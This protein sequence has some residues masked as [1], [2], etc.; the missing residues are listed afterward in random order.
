MPKLLFRVL[1]RDVINRR[2]LCDL[3]DLHKG[4]RCFIICNGPSLRVEDLER[5][6]AHGDISIG[7]NLIGRIYSKTS[8]RAD[9]LV[10]YDGICFEEGN[11]EI[12]D[13]TDCKGK[14]YG[15]QHFFKTRKAKGVTYYLNID[16]DRALLDAPQFS[17]DLTEK[18]FSIGTSA[19]QA[20]Q[21]ARWLG[22]TEIYIIGCD[23]SYAV[24]VHRDGSISKNSKSHFYE[25]NDKVNKQTIQIWEMEAAFDALDRLSREMGFRVYNATRG[26]HCES[27]ERVDVDTLF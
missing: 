17:L 13:A 3:K 19:Y 2:R 11:K 10:A 14:F 26:G 15:E 12:V 6:K 16:G 21:I 7:M 1:R 5:I 20:V 24:N 4:K 25:E 18:V 27:F 22:M 8:W 9:Y 23:M